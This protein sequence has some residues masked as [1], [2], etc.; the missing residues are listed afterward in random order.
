MC[1]VTEAFVKHYVEPVFYNR[2]STEICQVQAERIVLCRSF[3][4]SSGW[5]ACQLYIRIVCSLSDYKRCCY[6]WF[7]IDDSFSFFFFLNNLLRLFAMWNMLKMHEKRYNFCKEPHVGWS[8][9]LQETSDKPY[10][11]SKSVDK[12]CEVS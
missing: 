9:V 2:S 8:D 5:S 3:F 11:K 12:A 10:I 7:E 4:A 6:D 1:K